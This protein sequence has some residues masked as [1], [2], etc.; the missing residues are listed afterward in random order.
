VVSG[1]A[2]EGSVWQIGTAFSGSCINA[3]KNGSEGND[4]IQGWKT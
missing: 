2:K 4:E 3:C 1:G